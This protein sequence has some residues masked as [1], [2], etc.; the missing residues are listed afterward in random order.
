[1]KTNNKQ[2]FLNLITNAL[3]YVLGSCITFIITPIIIVK[4]GAEA[5]GFTGLSNNIISYTTIFTVALNSMSIRFISLYYLKK[6][7]YASN[8]YL[9]STFY[10]NVFVALFV[11]I[12]FVFLTL[13]LEKVIDIPVNLVTD[14]KLLFFFLCINSILSLITGVFNISTFV[15]N[16]LEKANI[17]NMIG[18]IIRCVMLISL[19]CVFQPYLWYFGITAIVMNIYLLGSNCLF[20]K[21]LTPELS[22]KFENFDIKK[23]FELLKSGVWN[24]VSS[25]ST[26]LNEGFDLLFA[27]IFISTYA[28]GLLSIT[29]IIPNYISS[30]I[31]SLS[32]SFNP[33]YIKLY[34]EKDKEK[35]KDTILKSIRM[36][37]CI[38]IIPITII[39]S[40]GDIFYSNWIPNEDS[41]I[42]YHLSCIGCF[43]LVFALPYQS[44]W[45]VF[46]LDD[47]IKKS[48][49]NALLNSACTFLIVLFCMFFVDDTMMRLYILVGTRSVLS[50]FRCLTF[51]PLYASKVLDFS[52]VTFYIPMLKNTVIIVIMTMISVLFKVLFLDYTWTGLFA[53]SIFSSVVALILGWMLILTKSDREYISRLIKNKVIRF[54]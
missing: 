25:L 19:F 47:K 34:A 53:G 9:A 38:S 29:K 22:I 20:F 2:L 17:R 15:K 41:S 30:F 10:A 46:V 39:F 51:L 31:I 33:E 1:M 43:L 21:Y 45:Y 8:G 49:I 11:T 7:Y 18:T 3:S 6:E 50:S 36:L 13:F 27:N 37:G 26:L 52:K 54:A 28:M 32:S 5:Y 12:V 24:L 14:V 44:L 4:L 23:V 16:E 42:L 40:Y 35:L 48:S